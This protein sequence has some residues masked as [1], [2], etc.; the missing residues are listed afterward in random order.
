MPVSSPHPGLAYAEVQL[1][2]HSVYAEAQDLLRQYDELITRL[3]KAIDDKR[4]LEDKINDRHM[5]ISMDERGKHPDHSEAAMSRHLKELFHQDATLKQLR[6]QHTAAAADLSG[7]ELEMKLTEAQ[8]RVVT[9]RL[10]QMGGYFQYLAAIKLGE[11]ET[12]KPT[13]PTQPNQPM[14]GSNQ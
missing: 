11:I 6:Q 13:Q 7:T 4:I 14:T 10:T 3:D 12:K 2:V 8:L 9:A 5:D 1:G